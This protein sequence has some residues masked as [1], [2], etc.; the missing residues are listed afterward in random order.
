MLTDLGG[1]PLIARAIAPA[2]AAGLDELIV[3]AGAV[4][5]ADVVPAEATLL[6]NDDW[7]GGQATSLGVALDWC[8][9]QHHAAAV[10][11]L[12]DVPG[13]EA[14]AWR[15]V[16]THIGGPIVVATYSGRRGHPVRLD[17]AVWSL[18]PSS[19]EEGARTL[20]SRRPELVVEVAC[21]GSPMDIDTVEDLH[22]WR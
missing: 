4:D 18:L 12:G 11:G 20:M 14:A 3:V 2:L 16:A 7:E 1:T 13:L 5:I 6:Q 21:S 19:G 9:R 17:A 8:H 15:R 22:R 10:V